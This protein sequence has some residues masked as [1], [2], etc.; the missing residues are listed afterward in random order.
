MR[1]IG[2]VHGKVDRYLP[3]TY[4]VD[5]IQVGDMGVGFT[6]IPVLGPNNRFIRGNHDCP[7]ECVSHPNWIKD[8][9]VE[10]D[11]MF[12]GGAWSI[13]QAYRI[14]GVSWWRDEE[15]SI[16]DFDHMINVALAAQPR[17]MITHDCPKSAVVPLFGREPVNTRTQQALDVI[18][19]ACKPELWI[20]GH[21][22]E[23]RDMNIN[24]TRFICLDELSYI[25]L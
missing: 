12:I 11:T 13:D 2:D 14:E 10:G 19:T 23:D 17:V 18:L 3:L 22:H 15:L 20:F 7:E 16:A 24:G 1:Y 9:T 25:D 21:W 4:G 5:S 6:D 8:G